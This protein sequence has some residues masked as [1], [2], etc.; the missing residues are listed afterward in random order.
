MSLSL[1]PKRRHPRR[2]C[3]SVSREGY[4]HHASDYIKRSLGKGIQTTC[5][6]LWPVV[7]LSKEIGK[8]RFPGGKHGMK[9]LIV[10]LQSNYIH[11]WHVMEFVWTIAWLWSRRVAWLALFRFCVCFC[12]RHPEQ[13]VATY[14]VRRVDDTED[15]SYSY[16]NKNVVTSIIM[17]FTWTYNGDFQCILQLHNLLCI[18]FNIFLPLHKFLKQPLSTRNLY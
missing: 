8:P 14:L 18:H 11:I 1:V 2:D 9:L 7:P 13:S 3:V 17:P 15:I 16:G 4:T 5:R 6:F 12:S 10:G